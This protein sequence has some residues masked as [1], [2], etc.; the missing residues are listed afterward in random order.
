[1]SLASNPT[2]K[3]IYDACPVFLQNLGVSLVGWKKRRTRYSSEFDRYV[4][5]FLRRQWNDREQWARYQNQALEQLL[6][7]A[8]RTVPYY[9]DLPEIK[10]D[11]STLPRENIQALPQLSPEVL[12]DRPRELV[13][14]SVDVSECVKLSTSGTTGTP[15]ISYHDVRSHRML[16]A[17]MERFYR[18][19]GCR[20]GDR[21]LSFTGNKIVP[22]QQQDGPFGRYDRANNRLL[23]SSY[24]L[25]PNT[26]DQYL[27]EIEDFRPHF[28]DGYPSSIGYCAERALEQNRDI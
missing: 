23:M 10:I 20:H 13:S 24:H 6:S 8:Q 3:F 2:L 19:A 18:R 4:D 27:D 7:Y 22:G 21:Q 28:I 9:A 14:R 25:G 17:A 16:K 12:K 26:V 5:A 15:K 11:H 1:M